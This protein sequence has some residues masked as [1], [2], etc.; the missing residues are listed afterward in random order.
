MVAISRALIG[1]PGLVLASPV[2]AVRDVAAGVTFG[3]TTASV[4]V[5]IVI[6]VQFPVL[7]VF[8]TV[9]AGVYAVG[10][11]VS[12]MSSAFSSGKPVAACTCSKVTPPVTEMVRVPG[13][14]PPRT[15]RDRARM[16]SMIVP[17]SLT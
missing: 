13:P 10:M 8:S 7:V 5:G 9:T 12:P 15:K 16:R 11:G 14:M 2:Q 1:A 4:A 17:L 6:V 3:L